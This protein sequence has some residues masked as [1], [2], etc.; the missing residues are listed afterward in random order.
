MLL[1]AIP[2]LL[3]LVYL[4]W[5]GFPAPGAASGS[6]PAS[7]AGVLQH[8][9]DRLLFA[10]A[11][12][13]HTALCLA[14]IVYFAVQLIRWGGARRR[15]IA[16][17]ALV[18]AAGVLAAMVGLGLIDHPPAVYTYTYYQIAALL[19]PYAAAGDLLGTHWGIPV[20]ALCV[21]LPTALGVIAVVTASGAATAV[22]RTLHD[23][24][25][26][27]GPSF[28]EGANALLHCLYV[29][30]GVLVTSTT[31]AFLF[32]YL[33]AGLASAGAKPGPLG[34]AVTA[35]AG[36]IGTFW[37]AIYT[38]TLFAVFAG[39]FAVLYAQVQKIVAGE[40][41]GMTVA[42]WLTGQGVKLTLGENVKHVIVLI[43]P[44]LVGP[45]GD[46]FKLFGS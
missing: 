22:I 18:I 45:L 19:R 33:P 42:E 12:A 13:I 41:K 44:L 11:A 34:A 6:V 43:A 8:G 2:V 1:P 32:F 40:E 15:M 10:A 7:D 39:P 24:P 36:G 16:V 5:I 28:R 17:T 3:A 37:A 23:A 14:A 31:A 30:S 27:G 29:L 9:R 35:Y 21:L 46:I 20:L 38:L 4:E 25:G 26:D